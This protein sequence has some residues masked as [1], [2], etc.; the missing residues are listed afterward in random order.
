MT[1]KT[2]GLNNIPN[3]TTVGRWWRWFVSVLEE[4]FIRMADMLQLAVATAIAVV[5]STPL[6]DLYDI[7]AGWGYTSRGKFRGLS[8]MPQ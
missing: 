7:E 2:L 4:T 8:F 3:R 6:E 1:A 5:D